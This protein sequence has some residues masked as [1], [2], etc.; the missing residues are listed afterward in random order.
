MPATQIYRNI[1]NLS[2]M[3]CQVLLVHYFG[4]TEPFF[5]LL[6]DYNSDHQYHRDDN[7]N[8]F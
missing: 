7:E 4:D 3:T 5:G 1:T 6:K 2:N 8:R